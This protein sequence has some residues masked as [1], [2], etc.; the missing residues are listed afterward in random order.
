[1]IERVANLAGQPPAVGLAQNDPIRAAFL[2]RLET[3]QGV[4]RVDAKAVEKMLG[5]ENDFIDALFH[6]GDGIGDDFEIGALADSQIVAHVQVPGL[7]DQGHDRRFGSE[8]SLEID[9]LGRLRAELAGRAERSDFDVLQFQ[10]SYLL[11]EIGVALIGS[12]IAAFDIVDAQVFEFLR[13]AE[14][15]FQRERDVF[16]LAAVPESRVV[17]QNVFHTFPCFPMNAS[18]STRTASSVYLV[19][20][21]TEIL[22]S[23][24]EII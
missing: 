17:E 19:S 5:V 18:C 1:V 20:I 11:E 4:V 15:V 3:L 2:G 9:I 13:D 10:L 8:Q 21:T 16:G 7:A 6:E 12:R 23:D 24:V 22:I 14:F